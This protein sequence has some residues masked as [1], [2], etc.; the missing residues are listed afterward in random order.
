MFE[1][2]INSMN[3]S[4]STPPYIPAVVGWQHK[5]AAAATTTTTII[6]N[7]QPTINNNN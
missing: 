5:M 2:N 1:N 4:T 6:N 3:S 7:Q